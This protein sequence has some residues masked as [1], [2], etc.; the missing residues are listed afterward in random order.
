MSGLQEG[1]PFRSESGILRKGGPISWPLVSLNSRI[2]EGFDLVTSW[3]GL[4]SSALCMWGSTLANAAIFAL[5]Y[6]SVRSQLVG[7]DI[8]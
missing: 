4:P 6:P 1:F 2:F 5:V 8:F 3:K 7:E